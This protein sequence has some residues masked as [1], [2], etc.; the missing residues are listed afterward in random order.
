MPRFDGTG[1]NG[2]GPGTGAMRGYCAIPAEDYFASAAGSSGVAALQRG[3]N[4]WTPPM[5]EGVQCRAPR[6]ASRGRSGR[7][8]S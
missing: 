6:V 3:E 5:M 2:A 4:G 1:P 7:R 8:Q